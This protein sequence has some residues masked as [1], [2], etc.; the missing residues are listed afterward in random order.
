MKKSISKKP[1]GRVANVGRTVSCGN[2]PISGQPVN[3]RHTLIRTKAG[4]LL[5]QV[6]PW[7]YMLACIMDKYGVREPA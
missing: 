5:V 1:I 7:A 4:S 2:C 6:H 3:G